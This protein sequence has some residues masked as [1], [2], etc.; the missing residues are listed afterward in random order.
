[1]LSLIS[2]L[3]ADRTHRPTIVM[4]THHL[5]ELPA[6]TSQVLLLREGRAVKVGSPKQV[7]T[8]AVVSKAYRYPL[9]VVRRGGRYFM[10]GKHK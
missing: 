10:H 4:I 9:S 7:L 1:M 3:H 2:Q 6:I 8:S 5:E